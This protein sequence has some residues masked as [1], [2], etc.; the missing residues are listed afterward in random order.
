MLVA[1]FLFLATTAQAQDFGLGAVNNGLGGTL[2]ATDP[3]ILIGRIIQ[4]A[5]SFLGVIAILIIMYAGFLW[6]SSGGEE[7]KISQARTILKNGVIGLVI[8]L[9]AWGIA[10]FII[11]R[12]AGAMDGSAPPVIPPGSGPGLTGVGLSSFGACSVESAYPAPGQQDLPRNTSIMISFK[13]ELKLDSVCLNAAGAPCACDNAACN[14]INPLGIRLYKTD[15]G[16]A[17]TDLNCPNPN[18]NMTAL[19]VN[20][21]S[22]KK[23]LV[24]IPEDYLGSV[25]DHTPYT[26]KFTSH[27]K[28][29]DGSS[30][31]ATCATDWAEWNFTVANFLDLTPPQILRSGLFPPTDNERDV[32]RQVVSAVPARASLTVNTCPS[33]YSPANLIGVSPGT[34]S[35]VLD[36]RGELNQFK[37]SVPAGAP[38]KAQLF[39]ASNNLLGLADFN[40]NGRVV[41]PNFLSLTA[42]QHP[43]G[44]LWTINLQPEKLADNLIVGDQIYTFADNNNNN[45]IEVSNPCDTV[46]QTRAISSKLSGHQDLEVEIV[47]GS[48]QLTAKVAGAAGNSIALS[49]TNPEALTIRPFRGGEN[50]QEMSEVRDRRDRPMNSLLQINFSEAINPLTVS[51][52]ATELASY[53]RVVNAGGDGLAAQAVCSVHSDCRSYKCENSRCI[54]DYIDGKFLVSNA[55]RTV[56][57]ISNQECGV[58]GCG[59]K[60]YCLPPSSH[61]SVELMAADLKICSS[62]NDCLGSAPFRFCRP[63]G[64]GYNTCQTQDGKNYPMASV[65]GLNGI[66]DA[67]F[68]SLDGNRD[69]YADGPLSFY[70]ENYPAGEDSQNK[71]KFKWS[72]YINDQIMLTPPQITEIYPQSGQSSASSTAP[73]RIKFNTLMMNS[74]LRSGSATVISGTSTQTHKLVNLWSLSPWPLGYWISSDNLDIEPL[75]GEPDLTFVNIWHSPFSESLTFNAQVGSGVKD[76]YQ[77]CYKPSAGPDCEATPN[78]PS[79]CFGQAVGALP[80]SGNCP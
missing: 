76:I 31:F 74:S 21:T 72:F 59:E 40:A 33:I 69:E 41:F 38:D 30:M 1:A 48:V 22:D 34:A 11:S 27:I 52:S 44:S 17:C 75:D 73:V 12:L 45:N 24:L 13:E 4:I 16:D 5:L 2:T 64:L 61:L 70:Y 78:Q 6:M 29:A 47:S 71:D 80:A 28:K 37:V 54:G 36:Y 19:A 15:L 50:R 62:D 18:G 79:C 67:A 65:T 20:V 58:N 63:T 7:E 51:G 23:T 32:W 9:S 53:I 49:T 60:I 42:S 57:F 46:T 77:N 3:R 10:T 14:R 66:V 56:E 55:Y 26:V 35:V 43:E 68:N 25:N 39:D 8:I